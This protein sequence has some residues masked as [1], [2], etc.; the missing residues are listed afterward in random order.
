LESASASANRMFE[1]AGAVTNVRY[2]EAPAVSPSLTPV[3]APGAADPDD[4]ILLSVRAWDEDG[5]SIEKLAAQARERGWRVVLF[6]S[7]QGLPESF[8]LDDLVDN[9]ARSAGRE[10]PR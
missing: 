8:P 3:M 6:A 1:H 4:V 5:K 9:H 7:R 2:T 10:E